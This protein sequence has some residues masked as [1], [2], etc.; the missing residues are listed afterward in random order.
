MKVYVEQLSKCVL[1]KNLRKEEIIN[2]FKEIPYQI[3]EYNKNQIIA[4]EGDDCHS[5]G[6]I[7]KGKVEIQKYFPL[8]KL[9]Q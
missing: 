2:I 3:I 4:I 5:L 6:I 9:L 8:A 7:L 1:F